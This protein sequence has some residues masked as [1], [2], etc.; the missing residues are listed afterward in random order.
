MIFRQSRMKLAIALVLTGLAALVLGFFGFVTAYLPGL[1]A[2]LGVSLF[3]PL[4]LACALTAV[5][6]AVFLSKP[7]SLH[8]DD[9]GVVWTNARQ[10][11][12]FG[13]DAI[14]A[15]H[16]FSPMSRFRSPGVELKEAVNGRRFISFGRFWETSAEEI[17]EALEKAPS[18]A[19]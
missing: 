3:A 13:W 11:R 18:K 9:S 5:K 14:A 4:A 7:S 8:I 1:W 10:T 2:Y 17:V 15:P 12:R 19:D 16:I 6:T